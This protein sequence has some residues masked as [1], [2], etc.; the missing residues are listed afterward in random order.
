MLVEWFLWWFVGWLLRSMGELL[1]G[2]IV[3]LCSVMV[4][5]MVGA[6]YQIWSAKYFKRLLNTAMP[7]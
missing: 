5:K 1:Y 3:E 7:F 6:N 4:G 2:T